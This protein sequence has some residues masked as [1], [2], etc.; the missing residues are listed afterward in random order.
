MPIVVR[1]IPNEGQ[2]LTALGAMTEQGRLP[3]L[4]HH[5]VG[6]APVGADAQRADSDAE[7]GVRPGGA[8]TT[9]AWLR[10]GSRY[11]CPYTPRV[12][13]RELR[14]REGDPQ[15]TSPGMAGTHVKLSRAMDTIPRDIPAIPAGPIRSLKTVTAARITRNK[16]PA[17]ATGKTTLPGIPLERASPIEVCPHV[18]NIPRPAPTM[19]SERVGFTGAREKNASIQ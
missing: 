3:D 5:K 17:S 8:F 15:E 19:M 11:R 2:S 1:A 14:H 7:A 9:I 13:E 6:K 4:R 16:P 18:L 12:S 10:S